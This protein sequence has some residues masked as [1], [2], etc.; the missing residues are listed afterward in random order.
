MSLDRIEQEEQ[1]RIQFELQLA[2]QGGK[3]CRLGAWDRERQE[4]PKGGTARVQS[5][6]NYILTLDQLKR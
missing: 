6:E 5:S 2:G 4:N 1:D 3:K